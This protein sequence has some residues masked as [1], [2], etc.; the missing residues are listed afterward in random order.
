MDPA[1]RILELRDL[2][3]HHEERYYI[4]EDPEIADAEFDELLRELQRLE[5]EHPDLVSID[6]P[7]QR[8]GGRAAAGFPTVTHAAPM[9]SLD[10]AYNEEELREFDERVRR[11][12]EGATAGAVAYVAEL[13]IDGLSIALT[14]EDGR[15]VR[16]AT[17]GDGTRGED[18]TANVRTIRPIP[19]ALRGAL[20]SPLEVRGEVYLPRREFERTNQEREQAG[21]PIFANPRNAAAGAMR[22]VDP[23]QVARRNLG[24]FFYQIVTDDPARP[25][26]HAQ[27]LE[28]LR[29]AGLPV[30]RHWRRCAGMDEVWAFCQDWAEQRRTL[31]F[32]TDGVV[33]KVDDLALRAALG[34]T[35]KFPRWAIAFKFPAEQAT[36]LLRAIDVNVGR[37]G[38]VTPFAV[39]EPVRLAGTTVQ[40]ASLHNEQ[41]IAR[42]DIRQGDYVLVEK[43]GDIIPQVIKPILARRPASSVPWMMPEA[44]P[45]CGSRLQKPDDEAVWRCENTSCPAKLQRGLEHFASRHALNIE[46]LGESLIARL[47]AEGLVRTYADVFHLAADRLAA[48]ERMGKKSAANLVAQIDRARGG[49]LWR[50]IYGLGIRHVGERGAQALA[51]AF[52]SMGALMSASVEDLQQVP[53]VGP[54]V[55]SAVRSYFEQPEN[56]RLMEALAQAGVRMDAPIRPRAPAGALAGSSFVLTGTLATLTREEAGAAVEARGGRVIGSVSKKTSYLVAGAEPGSKLAKAQALGVPVLDEA[57]FRALLGL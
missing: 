12:L 44:C 8:V 46:G 16:G 50:L 32:D 25:S 21:E 10:N 35:S 7:T 4:L 2:I 36:T 17:R 22:N 13:K 26:T 29:T 45:V 28:Q 55:A 5:R 27:T 52:G 37:T 39:L 41:E 42:R 47:I 43:A 9:L 6:S 57:A 24:A 11:G 49:E 38:A 53:D 51:D 18:V 54:V 1:E 31:S 23:A 15:L 14:Y 20:P 34:S 40:L 48:I 33:V 30:E 3:R 19:L 56:R